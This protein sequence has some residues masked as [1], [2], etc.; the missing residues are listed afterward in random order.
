M[1]SKLTAD[2]SYRNDLEMILW[3]IELADNK[4]LNELK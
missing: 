1:N 3:N 2:K 4:S